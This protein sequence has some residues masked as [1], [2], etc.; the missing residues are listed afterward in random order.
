MCGLSFEQGASPRG[1]NNRRL[2]VWDGVCWSVAWGGGVGRSC[3]YGRAELFALSKQWRAEPSSGY[4]RWASAGG[5]S[6]QATS[7]FTRV[8]RCGG[9]AEGRVKMAWGA[10]IDGFAG[11]G[12][13]WSSK[14][15][16]HGTRRIEVESGL[17]VFCMGGRGKLSL[18]G[19]G[20]GRRCE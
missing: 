7:R 8:S 9:A 14:P 13:G 3:R 2:V 10:D 15:P 19:G 5:H 6:R 16:F 18:L 4:V 11:D 1:N 12:R 17:G 20:C